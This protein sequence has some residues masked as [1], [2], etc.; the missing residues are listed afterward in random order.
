META[1]SEGATTALQDRRCS[2][3]IQQQIRGI[4]GNTDKGSDINEGVVSDVDEE[5][6]DDGEE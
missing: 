3:K 5:D 2:A 6:E 1:V 4:G